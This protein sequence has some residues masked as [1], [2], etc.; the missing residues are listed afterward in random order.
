MS[1]LAATYTRFQF[2]RPLVEN[3]EKEWGKLT[4]VAMNRNYDVPRKS[5]NDAQV[6]FDNNTR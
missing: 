1:K 3:W 5:S 2:G 4:N 6:I